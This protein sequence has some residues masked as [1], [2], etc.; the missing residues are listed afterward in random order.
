MSLLVGANDRIAPIREK[1]SVTTAV[2]VYTGY[3]GTVA[4]VSAPLYIV[5]TSAGAVNITVTVTDSA[6]VVYTRYPTT[7]LAAG[8]VLS[9][10]LEG[11]PLFD[12]ET[13]NVT[14]G[15]ANAIQVIGS[16][17]ETSGGKA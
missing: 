14:A 3:A 2:A 5:N 7:S 11:H 12:T 9:V 10:D 17:S 4:K 16:V 6:G 15:T 13:L 1:L 8:A